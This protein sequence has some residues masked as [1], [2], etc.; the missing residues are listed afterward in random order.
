[1]QPLANQI[2]SLYKARAKTFA[3]ARQVIDRVPDGDHG[4][5]KDKKVN[6]L[7][8]LRTP[9]RERTETIKQFR[10]AVAAEV[11]SNRSTLPKVEYNGIIS[12]QPTTRIQDE[13][14]IKANPA[15]I[16]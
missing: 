4:R 10:K 14:R 6:M 15:R 8:T 1:L 12:N 9:K 16:A 5:N 7:F 2:P 3:V 11:W 13:T